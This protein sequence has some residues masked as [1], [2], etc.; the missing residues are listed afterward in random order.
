MGNRKHD[1]I[2]ISGGVIYL[3]S[4]SETKQ[5]GGPNLIPELI[6]RGLKYLKI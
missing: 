2:D 1:V 6:E 4:Y 5:M 3:Y